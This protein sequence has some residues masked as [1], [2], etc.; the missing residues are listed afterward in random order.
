MFYCNYIFPRRSIVVVARSGPMDY[1]HDAQEKRQVV[2]CTPFIL[3][4]QSPSN[5]APRSKRKHG[6][7]M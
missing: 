6:T 3:S 4:N 7:A 5:S 2:V 1:N